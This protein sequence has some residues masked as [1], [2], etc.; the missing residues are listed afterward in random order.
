ME[1]IM[2]LGGEA[3]PR[4]VRFVVFIRRWSKTKGGPDSFGPSLLKAM[5]VGNI[6][7]LFTT[8]AG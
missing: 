8:Y 6:N 3:E 5:V 7:M 1:A 4:T 2:A